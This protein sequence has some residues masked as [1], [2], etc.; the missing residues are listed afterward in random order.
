M[1]RI[2]L[3]FI[4]AR[5]KADIICRLSFCE[6]IFDD[7]RKKNRY[8]LITESYILFCL[9]FHINCCSGVG[10]KIYLVYILFPCFV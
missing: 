10:E 7:I 4:C 9:W 3:G 6:A 8:L 1:L 5:S 2:L